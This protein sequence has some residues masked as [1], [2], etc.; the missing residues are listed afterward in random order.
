MI[1]SIVA[2]VA[3]LASISGVTLKSLVQRHLSDHAVIKS[4]VKWLEG[5]QVLYAPFEQE[6]HIAVIKSIETIKT[7]T[8]AVRS[9][10]ADELVSIVMLHLVLRMSEQL[11]VL[12]ALNAN[13][14]RHAAKMYRA[15]QE[16]RAK[17]AGALA[18]LCESH[19]INLSGSTLAPLV[20]DLGFRQRRE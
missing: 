2:N 9:K 16:V 8:E 13:D 6:V 20:A 10:I 19:K 15:I 11:M 7:E 12:H 17:F 18:L 1:E 4:Y 3:S 14:P 5:K